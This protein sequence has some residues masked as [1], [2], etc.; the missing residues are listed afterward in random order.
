M[1]EAFLDKGWAVFDPDPAVLDWAAYAR[2]FALAAI[3]D[4]ANAHWLQCEGTW[5][6]GVDALPNDASGRIGGSAPLM[7]RAAKA[8]AQIYGPLPPLHRAQV[9]VVWPG[10]PRPRQGESNAA[11]T[12]RKTRFGAHVDGLLPI[13]PQRHRMLREP[14]GFI[15]GLALNK[16]DPAAS[17]LMLWD[18]SHRIMGAAF[19]SALSPQD[20]KDWPDINLTETYK[21]AR[22]TVFETCP[23]KPCPLEPGQAIL[24][25]RHLL[26]GIGPW[27]AG[28]P[29]N[30]QGRMIAYFRPEWQDPGDWITAR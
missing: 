28:S 26:H 30:N 23:C 9:S 1:V 5:F 20:P 7:G 27:Q 6:V 15:L 21:N 4:P 14:H 22:K 3:A 10:Y 25:H 12:Y 29:Q 16:A 13:G 18:G 24:L 2:P 8:L 17:P 11:F 19:A